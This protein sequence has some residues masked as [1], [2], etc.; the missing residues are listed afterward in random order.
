MP[1]PESLTLDLEGRLVPVRLRRSVQARRMSLR[2]DALTD[3]LVLVL[4]GRTPLRDG[5]KFVEAHREW[6]RLRLARL[7]P[8]SPFADGASVPLL[9][10]AHAIR[11]RPDARRGTWLEDGVI[12]VSG[13]A[14]F[15]ARRIG[16][17]LK[18][19]ARRA[20][21]PRAQEKADSLQATIRRITL[22][23]TRSRWG[24]CSSTGDLAFCW[25][26]VLAPAWVL[27]YVVAHEVAHLRELNHSVRF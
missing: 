4:P 8:R 26:L 6:V 23:D 17:F 25:R 5:A 15:L 27:D 22:R 7:P 3:S 20:I 13:D 24:S 18:E 21:V 11:H 12:C 14:A 16:D 1:D 2:L 9:G 10:I 19:E